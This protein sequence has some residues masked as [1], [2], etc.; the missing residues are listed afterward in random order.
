MKRVR[1][2]NTAVDASDFI[3]SARPC[4]SKRVKQNK[5]PP[6]LEIVFLLIELFFFAMTS[7]LR[8]QPANNFFAILEYLFVPNSADVFSTIP[9]FDLSNMVKTALYQMTITK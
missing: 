7:H 6:K 2:I 5:N 8:Y 3:R 1:S 9:L 4:I